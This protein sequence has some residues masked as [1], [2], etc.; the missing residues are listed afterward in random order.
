MTVDVEENVLLNKLK[1]DYYTLEVKE[2]EIYVLDEKDYCIL[3]E[4][5]E[6][7]YD[8]W[9]GKYL[10]Q[11]NDGFSIIDN[12]I[13]DAYTEHVSNLS[14]AI[15]WLIEESEDISG[16]VNI[17]DERK[18]KVLEYVS[19]IESLYRDISHGDYEDDIEYEDYD[20]IF[21]SIVNKL[22]NNF[23]ELDCFYGALEI[24]GHDTK[25]KKIQSELFEQLTLANENI[26]DVPDSKYKDVLNSIKYL[27]YLNVSN[28]LFQNN[29]K[30]MIEEIESYNEGLG[31]NGINS[32]VVYDSVTK[33]IQSTI[34]AENNT[35]LTVDLDIEKMKNWND[36]RP[37]VEM[38]YKEAVSKFDVD[39]EFNTL[40]N[41]GDPGIQSMYSVKEFVT[42]LENDK[43]YFEEMLGL[44]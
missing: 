43:Y 36:L 42:N 30:D 19:L 26:I 27:L 15:A 13:G 38:K 31:L 10:I 17:E 12:S 24:L 2:D 18:T 34:E 7:D 37:Y 4:M 9:K 1:F 32:E 35:T 44:V 6:D 22:P 11:C 29:E 23:E 28:L 39:E 3:S 25:D 14:V 8:D 33:T 40:W 16:G 21:E 41:C 5:Y 20:A